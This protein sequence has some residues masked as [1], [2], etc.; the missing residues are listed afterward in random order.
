MKHNIYVFRVSSELIP[1]CAHPYVKELYK[2]KV[3]S[4]EEM[5]A[6]FEII[7]QWV[8]AYDLRLSIHPSQFNVL[9][10]P[11]L[12]VVKRSIDEINAQTE[13]I[14][15]LMGRNVV[16]HVGGSYGDKESAMKR[17]S[18][19]L[20]Y[21]DNKLISIENDDKT[22]NVEQ[23]VSLCEPKGI[24]WVYDFHHDRCHPSLHEDVKALIKAYPPD[25]YHLSTG[26]PHKDSRPHAD[27]ISASDYQMFTE[28][29]SECGI[30]KAD[31]IFE[32]KKKNKAIFHIL[33]IE[34]DGYWKL[35]RNN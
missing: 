25:K 7:R 21:V 26:T 30:E 3:Q 14:K 16:I 13:W 19:N 31:V 29:L 2:E 32:A 28:Y 6:Y 11:K 20:S 10:S 23:V 12:E 33:E 22:Y 34:Q 35:E 5:Q 24:K 4:N 8:E 17:F 9:S 1:F 15:A 18:T 27:Y